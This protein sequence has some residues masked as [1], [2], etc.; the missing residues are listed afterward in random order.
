M[1]YYC[2]FKTERARSR[3]HHYRQ[4]SSVTPAPQRVAH[5][6]GHPCLPAL[7]ALGAPGRRAAKTS[8]VLGNPERLARACGKSHERLRKSRRCGLGVVPAEDAIDARREIRGCRTLASGSGK[9]GGSAVR[10]GASYGG[11]QIRPDNAASHISQGL[12]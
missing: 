11:T 2:V 4:L 6:F 7:V 12:K 10:D 9:V 8:H 1:L 5:L 3:V